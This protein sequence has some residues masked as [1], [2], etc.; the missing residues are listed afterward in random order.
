M[1]RLLGFG[2]L[3]ALALCAQTDK[4]HFDGVNKRGDHAMGFSH[5]KTTHHFRLFADGGAIEVIADDAQSRDEIRE[6]LSHIATMFAAGNFEMP[7]FIHDRVP[8]GVPAMKRLKR[9]I[10]YAYEPLDNG[11]RVR[12][13]T[14]NPDAVKAIH[15]FLRFQITDHKTGDSLDVAQAFLPVGQKPLPPVAL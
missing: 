2:L 12:I 1:K 5:E 15:A 11:G 13:T 3:A 7:M 4:D 10:K 6:H 9:Q 8:P 14:A